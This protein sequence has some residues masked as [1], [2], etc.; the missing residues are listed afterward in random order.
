MAD[1]GYQ[2]PMVRQPQA[3][4]PQAPQQQGNLG[5]PAGGI[6]MEAWLAQDPTGSSYMKQLAEDNKPIALRQ[7]DL[8]GRNPDGTYSSRFQQ[9]QS[10]PGVLPS[11]DSNGQV[12]SFRAGPGF[13]DA[14][15][16]I[17]GAATTAEQ[18]AK[19]PFT[20]IDVP[21][22]NRKVFLSDVSP[23]FQNNYPTTA[24]NGLPRPPVLPPTQGSQGVAK[25]EVTQ[26]S[27]QSKYFGNQGS[28][29]SGPDPVALAGATADAESASKNRQKVMFDDYQSL[30]GQNANAQTV[31]SRLQTIK[32]LGPQALTGA[33]VEKRDFFNG[34]LTL[35]GVKGA[36]DAKTAGDLIDKNASQIAL[37]IGAG[38]NGTDALRSLAQSAN[39]S[40]HMT[41]EAIQKAVD[42]L[43]A[44][45]E[46]TQAKTQLLTQH[47]SKGD[48]ATYLDKKQTFERA[49]DPRVWELQRL[50][51]DQQKAYI[52]SL[53]PADA[54]HLLGARSV[55]KQLGALQ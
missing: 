43:V 40:R 29:L 12:T 11:R 35:V 19:A 21:G 15:A 18:V 45:L 10:V 55:L 20:A 1:P 3:P 38:S 54:Q 14:A 26:P 30:S 17:K 47:F 44:P 2:P 28:G 31:I 6:P 50:P 42:S 8:V 52:S 46:M 13:A 9:P 53:S 34:L 5:G 33:Q 22:A 48:A 41:Q 39:P 16:S 36:T 27:T 51:P 24:P 7:G 23:Y 49:A 37:A 32:Q 4:Q 25:V